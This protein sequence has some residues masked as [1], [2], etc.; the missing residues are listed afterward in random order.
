M[1]LAQLGSVL[2][3]ILVVGLLFCGANARWLHSFQP[4]IGESSIQVLKVLDPF[5]VH[6]VQKRNV[7][8]NDEYLSP[9]IQL[10]NINN[11]LPGERK[12]TVVLYFPGGNEK[13][14]LNLEFPYRVYIRNEF[15]LYSF[16]CYQIVGLVLNFKSHHHFARIFDSARDFYA[17]RDDVHPLAQG[18][19]LKNDAPVRRISR[20]SRFYRLPTNYATRDSSHDN[21]HPVWDVCRGRQFTPWIL[22]RLLFGTLFLIGSFVLIVECHRT[23]LNWLGGTL[24]FLGFLFLLAPVPWDLGPCPASQTEGQHSEYRQTFQHDVENVSQIPV[25]FTYS[26]AIFSPAMN[27]PSP[28]QFLK[29]SGLAGATSA[30]CSILSFSIAYAEHQNNRNVPTELLKAFGCVLFC[31]GAYLAWANE[32]KR[33]S[34]LQ[35]LQEKADIHAEIYRASIDIKRFDEHGQSI[36]VEDG[37]CVS[38][39]MKAVNHGH[40][41][42]FGNWPMLEISLAKKTY[43]GTSTRIPDSPWLL[44]YDDLSLM[45]RRVQ[46]LFQSV[47]VNG[48]SW[49][50]G[51][52]RVGTLSFIVPGIDHNIME[53][54]LKVSI[55]VT[56]FDSLG[57]SHISNFKDV[58]VTKGAIQT[59]PTV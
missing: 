27:N 26:K 12:G 5:P 8:R 6:A 7:A 53:T 35:A 20:F 41:A 51:L 25:D 22:G 31:W 55:R 38:L 44:Q 17:K 23:W 14:T 30:L 59:I 40:D 54:E 4:P 33:C 45:D 24:L 1:I 39:L 2:I 3:W 9:S 13:I 29:A 43:H 50:H 52:P 19:F 49:P 36:P 11:A 37:V 56:F 10:A 32:R 42:W 21:Q 47:F 15:V 18:R 16:D 34:D 28:I 48:P 46:S 57:N 58:P